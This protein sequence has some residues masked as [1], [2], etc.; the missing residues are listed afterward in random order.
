MVFAMAI[1]RGFEAQRL[2]MRKLSDIAVRHCT[3]IFLRRR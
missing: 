1:D 2:Y 3:G